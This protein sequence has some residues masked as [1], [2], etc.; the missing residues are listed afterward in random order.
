MGPSLDQTKPH[1][2]S[3]SL[4]F[5]QKCGTTWSPVWA[6]PYYL[7]LSQTQSGPGLLNLYK[8]YTNIIFLIYLLI[9]DYYVNTLLNNLFT[10]MG[11]APTSLPE[12]W[13]FYTSHGLC[14]VH[15]QT[16]CFLGASGQVQHMPSNSITSCHHFPCAATVTPYAP[17]LSHP[18]CPYC[19]ALCTPTVMPYAPPLLCPTCCHHCTHAPPLLCPMRPMRRATNVPCTSFPTVEVKNYF[20]NMLHVCSFTFVSH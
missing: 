12:L 17:P 5:S 9:I 11:G 18:T 7:R 3:P 6:I 10:R 20:A 1:S 15:A 13:G 8:H 2:P 4:G 19:C 16:I 14:M